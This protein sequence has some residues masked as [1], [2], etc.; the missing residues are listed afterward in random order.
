[1]KARQM[2]TAQALRRLFEQVHGGSFTVTYMDGTTEHHGDS[3]PQFNI[4]FCDDNFFDLLHGDMLMSFGDAYMD[5]RVDFEGDLADF[6]SLAL[7]SMTLDDWSERFEQCVPLVRERF[8]ERFV[9]MWRLYLRASSAAFREGVVEVHQ[10]LVSGGQ[11]SGL[12]L[13][14]EDLY[15]E[16]R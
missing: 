5:G 10:I 13:T 7:R 8:G 16:K 14:R 15:S 4:S 9:R 12:A 2:L 3:A 11:Q 6:M 1:M